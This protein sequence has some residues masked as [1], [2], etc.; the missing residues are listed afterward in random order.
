[1]PGRWCSPSRGAPSRDGDAYRLYADTSSTPDGTAGG[2]AVRLPWLLQ[3]V[4][5]QFG[6]VPR[7]GRF[8]LPLWLLGGRSCRSSMDWL[9]C[10]VRH[11]R[12][13]SPTT[14]NRPRCSSPLSG[15]RDWNDGR[16][17]G[18]GAGSW[19]DRCNHDSVSSEIDLLGRFVV[20]H[21]A[22]HDRVDL[23]LDAQVR[24]DQGAVAD[25]RPG[26]A[27]G[28]EDPSHL[29][30]DRLGIGDVGEE[31]AVADDVAHCGARFRQRLLDDAPGCS[32]SAPRRHRERRA[33]RP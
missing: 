30:A 11:R 19:R 6:L 1:M 25:H 13:R 28:A 31:D 9:R 7:G 5:S 23:D 33:R 27:D 26:R 15:L 17:P 24:V 2:V 21:G 16:C 29:V 10:A 4:A 32:G 20:L 8:H 12:R 3:C 22:I 18:V 14:C